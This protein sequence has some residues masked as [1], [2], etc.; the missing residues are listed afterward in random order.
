MG[1][2]NGTPVLRQE[3]IDILCNTSGMDEAKVRECFDNFVDQ[4][5][6]GRLDKG[7]FREMMENVNNIKSSFTKYYYCTSG[8]TKERR[9]KDGG[10]YF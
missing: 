3:D 9:K 2:K 6:D 4:H 7:D 5:P 1:N 10:S 8:F